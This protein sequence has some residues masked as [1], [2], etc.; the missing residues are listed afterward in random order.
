MGFLPHTLDFPSYV[1]LLC[2]SEGLIL[3]QK[4]LFLASIKEV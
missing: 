4:S 2:C 3:E 1:V